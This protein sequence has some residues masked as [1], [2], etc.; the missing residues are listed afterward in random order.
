MMAGALDGIRV[1]DF[2]QYIPGPLAAM[3][4]CDQ[5]AEVIRVD[6]PGGPLWQTPANAVWNRGKK[7]IV[8]DL[9]QATDR[10]S[11]RRLVA[12]ADVVIENFRPGVMDRLGLGPEEMI[13]SNPR[14]VYC[15]IPG[16]A[17]DDPRAA[18][19]GYEGVVA[20]ATDMYRPS[21]EDGPVDTSRPV[22]TPI[23]IAS[24][25]AAFMAAVSVTVA[26]IARE[27]D[28]LGQRIEVPLFDAMFDA[29][30]GRAGLPDNRRI[31]GAGGL[32]DT[33]GIYECS[34]GRWVHF[35]TFNP[36]F[37]EWFI[38]HAGVRSWQDDG[39]LDFR[40]SGPGPSELRKRMV[41]LFKTRTAQEWED[42]GKV[43]GLPLSV[44]RTDREW[45]ANEH[46]RASMGVAEV[47]DP[48]YGRMMQPGFAVTLSGSP[49]TISPRHPLDADRAEVLRMADEPPAAVSRPSAPPLKR[50]LE[51][52]RLVDTTE[53]L[54]APTAGRIMG[55]FGAD[56][57]KVNKVRDASI[58]E[59]VHLNRGKRTVLLDLQKPAGLDVLNRLIDG[60][61]V[62]M[63]N[64]TKGQADKLGFGYEQVRVR[65]PDIVY[66]S[67]SAYN[68]DG[69]WGT[70]RGYEPMGQATSGMKVRTGGDG[71]PASQPF[72]LNDYG[73]GV[74][75][76][77]AIAL[78]IFHRLR[79]GEGQHVQASLAQTGTFHQ[80]PYFYSY[81][82]MPEQPNWRGKLGSGPLYRLYRAEDDWFFLAARREQLEAISAVDGLGGVASLEG[83]AP[84]RAL[85]AAFAHKRAEEW[86]TLLQQQGI[87][88][89]TLVTVEALMEDPWVAAH[90]LS[91]THEIEDIGTV[92]RA[93]TTPRLSRTPA[94]AR[95]A[96]PAGADTV[97]VLREVG[98]ADE[99]VRLIEEGVAATALNATRPVAAAPVA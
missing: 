12:S 89:H 45:M 41:A 35:A 37:I 30:G 81:E 18:V 85:E 36:R 26:L 29:F 74:L 31:P 13:A 39:I 16:F 8:L 53:V 88:A 61:D 64:F 83:A 58:L 4:L 22:F 67:V 75:G 49:G 1:I 82:G 65:R 25:F 79:T 47:T 17:S 84:E 60:A 92:R 95:P 19:P 28:G 2:G 46:A 76:A 97:S 66:M 80:T 10:G 54:A 62:F 56:V 90:G 91:V 20:A 24:N 11:A 59:H 32:N 33:G 78:G 99:A 55:E 94:E 68:H 96:R 72:A 51:G 63:Q 9:K 98:L 14:L 43:A 21:R 6:P 71:P 38:D 48:E 34:D 27:R 70:G 3:L 23:T 7:S 50:A 73:T 15:S 42:L 87:G 40:R 77:F 69:P 52:I 44:C 57:I 5:G 93:G 86:V